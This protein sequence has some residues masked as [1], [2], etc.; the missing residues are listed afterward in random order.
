MSAHADTPTNPTTP[1]GSIAIHK[2]FNPNALVF[3][4]AGT[5]F[6]Q[7]AEEVGFAAEEGA[8]TAEVLAAEE[9]ANEVA[10]KTRA[11]LQ[12][13][14]KGK[15]VFPDGVHPWDCAAIDQL[16]EEYLKS[17]RRFE[18]KEAQQIWDNATE[19]FAEEQLDLDAEYNEHLEEEA[20][21]HVDEDQQPSSRWTSPKNWEDMVPSYWTT[22]TDTKVIETKVEVLRDLIKTGK[23]T[24]AP[25]TNP[26]DDNSLLEL[27]RF[28]EK[29][30]Y[31]FANE[32]SKKRFDAA[33]YPDK[34]SAQPGHKDCRNGKKCTKRDCTFSHPGDCPKWGL[35]FNFH[36]KKTHPLPCKNGKKCK[37]G[38]DCRYDHS[39]VKHTQ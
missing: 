38:A 32:E 39:S 1:D 5:T 37:F 26:E 30:N 28:I 3:V 12:L 18:D 34:P 31:K 14:K 35:C 24:C 17:G 25:G 21:G 23:A 20:E 33:V 19:L 36:C 9:F 8:F 22:E 15:F 10:C 27:A 16:V 4:P 7:A 2:P 6:S 29:I 13:A 11:L